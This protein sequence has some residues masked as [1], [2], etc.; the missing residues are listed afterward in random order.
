MFIFYFRNLT[1]LLT[2]LLYFS[3]A[4][5]IYFC[6]NN[7]N[8]KETTILLLTLISSLIVSVISYFWYLGTNNFVNELSKDLLEAKVIEL[9]G[10]GLAPLTSFINITQT[11]I[12]IFIIVVI[13]TYNILPLFFLIKNR[14]RS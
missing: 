11:N 9:S 8:I 1:Y 6:F 12:I 13:I 14:N 4:L 3:L 10:I 7:F 5:L 2:L